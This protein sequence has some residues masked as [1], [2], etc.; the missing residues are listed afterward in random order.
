MLVNQATTAQDIPTFQFF[1]FSISENDKDYNI[2]I[3][4]KEEPVSQYDQFNL[5]RE[6]YWYKNKKIYSTRGS[7]DGRLLH[8]D[9]KKFYASGQLKE[10]GHF[11]KGLKCGVWKYWDESGELRAVEHYRGGKK[12]GVFKEFNAS[13]QTVRKGFYLFGK[14]LFSR[15]IE[16]KNARIEKRQIKKEEKQKSKQEKS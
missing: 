7:A 9:Y 3:Y 2:E 1:T 13:G 4:L 8:G 15:S 12:K 6:Y 10:Q 14:K 16:S 11:I 5:K